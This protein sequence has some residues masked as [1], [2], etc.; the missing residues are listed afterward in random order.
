MGDWQALLEAAK[1]RLR[2]AADMSLE[3]VSR[4]VLAQ[5]PAHL[6][7]TALDCVMALEQL[8]LQL[9]H[10][11]ARHTLLTSE[12]DQLRVELAGLRCELAG[13]QAGERQARHEAL[14]DGLTSLPNRMHFRQRLEQALAPPP[15]R[16]RLL[17]LLYVDLDGLKPVNDAH[18]HR[19]GDELLRIVAARLCRGVRDHDLVGRIGGDEFACLLP[20]VSGRGQLATLAG[21]LRDAIAAPL[22]IGDM[23]MS[24]PASIGIAMY[25]GD[26]LSADE[27]LHNADAAMYRA[28]RQQLGYAFS[29]LST[30]T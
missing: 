11:L 1:A 4:P 9:D 16:D 3:A 27:L 6:R 28:K 2:S 7:A 23:A 21:R 19:A 12:V 25:P 8:Q 24:V 22:T 5:A 14:H 20:D 29:D 26:G 17:G 10:E 30:A 15:P 13:T 18:G